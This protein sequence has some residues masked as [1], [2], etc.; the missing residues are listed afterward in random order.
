MGPQALTDVCVDAIAK[1]GQGDDYRCPGCATKLT[2]GV[3]RDHA[4][5]CPALR[6]QMVRVENEKESPGSRVA[7][8]FPGHL[9]VPIKTEADGRWGLYHNGERVIVLPA[10]PSDEMAVAVMQGLLG[11]FEQGKRV[12]RVLMATDVSNLINER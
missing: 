3:A 9:I 11:A 12:G 5:T 7:Y 8:D 1:T 2:W 10:S 6:D 4:M